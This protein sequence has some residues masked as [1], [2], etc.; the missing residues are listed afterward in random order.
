ML[1]KTQ[2][3]VDTIARLRQTQ[4]IQPK[5]GRSGLGSTPCLGHPYWQSEEADAFRK[6][7]AIYLACNAVGPKYH[8][9]AAIQGEAMF[10]L[11]KYW[12]EKEQFPDNLFHLGI[13]E[14]EHGIVE[15]LPVVKVPIRTLHLR[16]DQYQDRSTMVKPVSFFH[17]TKPAIVLHILQTGL[18]ASTK[19]HG[20][21][22]VW[23]NCKLSWTLRWNTT[24]LDIFAGTSLE[25]LAEAEHVINNAKVRGSTKN[26]LR[27]VVRL[28]GSQPT[29]RVKT[30]YFLIPTEQQLQ[31]RDAVREFIAD[32][33][34]AMQINIEPVH[35]VSTLLLKETIA[36]TI[37]LTEYRLSYIGCHGAMENMFGGVFSEIAPV[38]S[39]LSIPLAAL[40]DAISTENLEKKLFKFSLVSLQQLG[41]L[42][43][44]WIRTHIGDIIHLLNHE[45]PIVSPKWNCRPKWTVEP[46]GVLNTTPADPDTDCD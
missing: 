9:A 28:V 10:L 14:A 36:D 33:I 39:S 2:Q 15:G 30:A 27:R 18:K 37:K 21:V 42:A 34:I 29:M 26:M 19:S 32:T 23:V 7:N 46:W 31:F 20:E 13:G 41:N 5:V 43:E 17:G 4:S 22:G 11:L 45:A 25:V 1:A 6:M 38:A 44:T 8:P 40:L 35:R 16:T 3:Q 12:Y 24:A